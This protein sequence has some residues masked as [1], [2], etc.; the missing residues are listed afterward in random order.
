[1]EMTDTVDLVVIGAF[2]G[3]G[4]RAGRFGTLLLAAYDPDADM[5]RSVCKVGTGFTDKDL[6]EMTAMFQD[7]II[8]KKHPR[9]DSVMT[10]DAWLVPHFVAEVI[11]A[12]LTLSPQHSCCRDAVRKGVGLSIR[13]PRFIRWRDDKAPEDATTPEELIEMY[14]KQLK[15]ISEE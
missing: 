2:K 12:E 6:E 8:P 10:P 15:K 3:K 5:F 7:Y 4:R 11:G 14:R 1:R 9:V 13:F